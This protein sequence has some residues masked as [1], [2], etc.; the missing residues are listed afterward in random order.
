M[1]MRNF[2]TDLDRQGVTRLVRT[3]TTVEIEE[4]V[5]V[6]R[7]PSVIS[8]A[9][10]MKDEWAWDDLRDYVVGQIEDRFGPFPRDHRKESGIFKSFLDRHGDRAPAI[11][12][13]AFE[14][15]DGYW[16]GSPISVNRFCRNSDVYFA[17]IIKARLA[18]APIE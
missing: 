12:R 14:V 9:H 1:T 7:H 18:E 10:L 13:F 2:D 4:T 16:K 5:E 3:E 11:A 6:V 8:K 17:D 15:A